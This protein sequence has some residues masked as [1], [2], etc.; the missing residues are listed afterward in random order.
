[1]MAG[2]AYLTIPSL[3][4]RRASEDNS[5]LKELE[6]FKKRADTRRV[7]LDT[8]EVRHSSYF[9]E[10]GTDDDLEYEVF[11]YYHPSYNSTPTYEKVNQVVLIWETT[12]QDVK[13]RFISPFLDKDE[14]TVR[15]KMAAAKNT[16]LYVDPENVENYFFDISFLEN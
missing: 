13:R 2:G 3:F 15:F 1:M 6:E 4:K 9:E 16:T 11:S 8:C 10:R 5:F 14:T 7:D 12:Y